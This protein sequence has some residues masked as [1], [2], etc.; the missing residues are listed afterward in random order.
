MDNEAQ[1]LTPEELAQSEKRKE[2]KEQKKFK[3]K[4]LR[5]KRPPPP[6]Q[7]DNSRF[8]AR[9]WINLPEVNET[10]TQHRVRVLTWNVTS[11]CFWTSSVETDPEIQL[12]AQSLV[13]TLTK[14]HVSMEPTHGYL[15]GR[16][17]FPTSNCLKAH[18]RENMIFKEITSSGADILCLQVS[19]LTPTLPLV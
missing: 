6:P 8:L 10:R 18:Q 12:L 14:K 11:H 16:E 17:L 5:N 9:P 13:R 4:A 1:E 15:L 2:R 19:K 7:P 3:Q